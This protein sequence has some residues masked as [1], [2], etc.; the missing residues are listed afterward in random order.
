PLV[1]GGRTKS[2]LTRIRFLDKEM[3]IHNKILTTNYNAN[4]NEVYQ[5]F[6]EN[7]LITKNTQ[8]ENIYDWLS[9]FKLLSIPKT[10]FKKK[11]LYSEKDRDIEGL[12][13][14]A[15]NDGNVMRYYDQETYVLYRKFYED[16]NI[17]EFED[18]MSPISKKKIE[19][20]EY[21]HFG[22]LHRKIYFSSRTYHKILEEYFDT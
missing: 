21:N 8:I 10:R 20:R 9:D 22:Q 19:R 14:K 5:K 18:V 2:L 7:Q 13:S 12:T 4:Y 1:H 17:I 16:T 3:G 15:F 11:T 6:E